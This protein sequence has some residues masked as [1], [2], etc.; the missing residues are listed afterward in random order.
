MTKQLLV[1]T[2]AVSVAMGLAVAGQ[3]TGQTAA[4]PVNHIVIPAGKT[5]PTD[6][7]Q[8][9]VSYCAP[10]HGADGKGAG[11]VSPALKIKPIDLTLLAQNNH[12]KFPSAHVAAVLQFGSE[13]PAHGS[14]QMP[15][16]GPIF[17]NM[18]RG[19]VQA[20]QLRIGNLAQYIENIQAK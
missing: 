15:V 3:T 4:Q 6:G 7:K 18:N 14:A 13:L 16:W 10:C 1:T 17:N 12:G 19:S 11:P 5:S 9:F 2:M 8:M 20:K